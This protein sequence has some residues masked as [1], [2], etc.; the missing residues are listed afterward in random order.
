LEVSKTQRQEQDN[1][2]QDKTDRIRQTGW[3]ITRERFQSSFWPQKSQK[4]PES[5]INILLG[6]WILSWE[7]G[8]FILYILSCLFMTI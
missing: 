7:S 5:Y 8:C 1:S 4:M 2:Q 3:E 6:Y